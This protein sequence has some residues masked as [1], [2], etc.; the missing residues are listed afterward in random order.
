MLGSSR[1]P[2][3]LRFWENGYAESFFSRLAEDYADEWMWR[4]AMHYRWNNAADRHLL[5]TR[6]AEEVLRLPLP[7]VLRRYWIAWRQTR[8]FVRGDAWDLELTP[9]LG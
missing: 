9:L 5:S 8:L 4:P 7:L 2:A 1:Y 3:H 6:L